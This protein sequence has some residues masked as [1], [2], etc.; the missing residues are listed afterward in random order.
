VKVLVAGIG[1]I[2][3]GDDAFGSGVARGLLDRPVPDGVEV[4]DFGIRGI[5]LAY[6]LLDGYDALVL[7]D[8]VSRGEEPGTVSL[9]KPD[10][11]LDAIDEEAGE[12]PSLVSVDAHG[13]D[14]VSVL[15]SLRGLG[16]HVERVLLV[17][18]EPL[19]AEEGMGL[20]PVV[21]A[22]VPRAVELVVAT[23]ERLM[24]GEPIGSGERRRAD[25]ATDVSS[26]VDQFEADIKDR[27]VVRR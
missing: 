8:A 5:H 11:D 14:P 4:A 10:I 21:E 12:G 1:N 23:V 15:R 9:I 6:Q 24:A 3:F 19:R 20:S 2:F 17:G 7:V 25:V 26:T 27:E 22:A 13:M 18:C 16:G